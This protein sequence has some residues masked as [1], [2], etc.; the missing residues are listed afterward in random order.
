MPQGE[1]DNRPFYALA[2]AIV[3]VAL[4]FL[5]PATR[6][7]LLDTVIEPVR[8]QADPEPGMR[9]GYTFESLLFWA[10]LGGVFAW[11]AYEAVFVRWRFEPN[12]ELFL[13]LAPA[14]L[15]GPL[16]H[17]A[18]IGRVLP[19]GS[20][21]AYMG[22]EPL[23]YLTIAAFAG[24]GLALGRLAKMPVVLPLVWGA[25]GIAP[26]LWRLAPRVTG[27]S[28]RLALIL[29]GLAVGAALALA[30]AYRRWR[31]D[32]RFA[33]I[34]PIIGA[35]ALDGATTW[36]VLR[37]PFGLG[38]VGF[39]E[40]NPVSQTLV[41]LSNGWPYF[42]LKLALPV[43]L[44]AMVRKEESEARLR[45]FLLFAVFILGFGPGMANLLQ[46]LFG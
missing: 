15:L 39:G 11:A 27:E 5:V 34:F 25:L 4:A 8:A 6:G 3:I 9:H 43:V 32:E 21:L 44:L 22:S 40:R 29:L 46:V 7:W 20:L 12:E 33:V 19:D 45:A 1:H 42:A 14:L 35:H 41:N 30:E 10:L 37:D 28:A 17:A 26:I 31:P 16:L 36:M 23:V 18:L 24:I 13:A 38:F 2:A